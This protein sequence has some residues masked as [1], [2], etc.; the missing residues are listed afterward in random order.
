MQSLD[1]TT[2][3]TAAVFNLRQETHLIGN[4]YSWLG[5]LFFLGWIIWEYP[6]NFLLQ[7]F[8]VG[9]TLAATVLPFQPWLQA[10]VLI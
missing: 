4:Q 10:T 6:A 5:S 9:K 2:L 8:P 1:K 3:G 7:R